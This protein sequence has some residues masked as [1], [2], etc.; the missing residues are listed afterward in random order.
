MSLVSVKH[1]FVAYKKILKELSLVKRILNYLIQ[2]FF[3]GYYV[4][5]ICT[6]LNSTV[7]LVLYSILL[8]VLIVSFIFELCVKDKK[9]DTKKIKKLRKANKK[10]FRLFIQIIKYLAKLGT[11]VIA[12][13][14][15]IVYGGTDLAIILLAVSIIMFLLKLGADIGIYLVEKYATMMYFAVKL[16]IENSDA[17]KAVSNIVREAKGIEEGNETEFYTDAELK[18]INNL[19]EEVG[20]S[21][22]TITT[23]SKKGR[24]GKRLLKFATRKV[25]NNLVNKDNE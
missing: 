5:L 6:H 20:D 2:A 11:I 9:D 24:L 13:I 14:E 3:L 22:D 25:V 7:R 17:I 10:R 19:K 18:I 21:G 4:Y 8:I 12:I 15:I 16:D 23:N 1:T